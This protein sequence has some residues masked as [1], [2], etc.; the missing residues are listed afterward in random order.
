VVA[1][2]DR[3]DSVGEQLLGDARRQA[4][5]VGRVLAVR[6]AEVDVELGAELAEPLLQRAAPRDADDVGDEEQDQGRE[7][8][9]AGK[10]CNVTWLPASRV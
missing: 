5:T 8:A 10:I 2:R 9:A 6:D 3:V 4:D 1:E 7:R